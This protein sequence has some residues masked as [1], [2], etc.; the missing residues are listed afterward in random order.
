MT[1]AAKLGARDISTGAEW[2]IAEPHHTLI[3]HLG[4]RM[5]ALE[6]ELDGHCTNLGPAN[7][8]EYWLIP[9]GSAYAAA[10]RGQTIRFVEI[11]IPEALLDADARAARFDAD[12]AGL[13]L[14][15]AGGDARATDAILERLGASRADPSGRRM[16]AP[17]ARRLRML[18][19]DEL[20]QP[21]HLADLAAEAGTS[22]NT[23][24]RSFRATFGISPAQFLI[25]QRLRRAQWL[26]QETGEGITAI[27]LRAGFS[28]HALLTSHF[29]RRYRMS[30][31][32]WRTIAGA[33][34]KNGS[35]SPPVS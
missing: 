34:A 9:A 15:S 8:A 30:P 3:V 27:A 18:V 32:E 13:A 10:A 24:L 11:A 31:R 35:T 26:L 5:D 25:E 2:Q 4:G 33:I 21:L 20:G 19:H 29:S 6:T 7:P 17:I 16:A 22:V 14:A 1:Y 23:L 28:S 12:L